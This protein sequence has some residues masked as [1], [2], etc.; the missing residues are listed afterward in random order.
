MSKPISATQILRNNESYYSLVIAVAKRARQIADNAI[1]EKIVLNEK[2]VK[3]AIDEFVS[4]EYR[5]IED[6]GV[7]G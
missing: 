4:G 3:I 5:L 6:P 2:P 1:E 7:K